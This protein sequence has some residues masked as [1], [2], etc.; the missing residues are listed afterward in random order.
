MA[1]I[2]DDAIKSLQDLVNKLELRVKELED[3]IQHASGG[4]KHSADEGVRMIL[5]GP[6]G[7]GML[8]ANL[9][10]YL[11][12]ALGAPANLQFIGK[13]TQAPK[14]KEKF[15]CCH[16]VSVRHFLRLLLSL[17]NYLAGHRRYASIASR[18]K[19]T[20]RSGGQEDHG[21]GWTC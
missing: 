12:D 14:I 21:S 5:M 19:D 2:G 20:F 1:P 13:G 9:R 6:P 8:F 17:P 3:R 16:L 11:K 18:K 4:T 10:I 7:A 15:S